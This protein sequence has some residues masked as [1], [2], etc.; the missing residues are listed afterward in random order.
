LPQIILSLVPHLA[1]FLWL[2]S[3]SGSR[4]P[5][6]Q[7]FMI[8]HRS[9]L[10]RATLHTTHQSVKLQSVHFFSLLTS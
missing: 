2:N 7:G 8:T 5:H 9:G 1:F 10:H 3:P 4:P 6:F